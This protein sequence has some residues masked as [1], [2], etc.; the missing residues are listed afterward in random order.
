M[1]RFYLLATVPIL[2][3]PSMN[4]ET[5]HAIYVTL[6]ALLDPSIIW[7]LGSV[8]LG[9]IGMKHKRFVD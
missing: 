3:Y 5:R 4:W 9:L 8:L 1:R 6:T 2:L 7:L